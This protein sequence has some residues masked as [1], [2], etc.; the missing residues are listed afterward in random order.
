MAMDK[1]LL[2]AILGKDKDSD[3]DMEMDM[4]KGPKYKNDDEKSPMRKKAMMKF[5]DKFIDAVKDGDVEKANHS[6]YHWHEISH[7]YDYE[8]NKDDNS[9][10]KEDDKYKG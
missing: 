9:S 4:D 2:I 6:L 5:M 7:S 10:H 3:G 1:K 8:K